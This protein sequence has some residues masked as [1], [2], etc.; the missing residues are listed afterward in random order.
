MNDLYT[1]AGIIEKDVLL[2]RYL[3]LVRYEALKL[4]VRLPASVQLDDLIQ[5]G[6]IGLLDASERFDMTQV[7]AFVT[8]AVQ[9][10]RGAMLDEL[11]ARDWVPRSLC[12]VWRGKR[13][14]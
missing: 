12:A 3:P 11:R 2:E 9:R 10:G 4:Q 7:T 8:Y 14:K 1:Q 13:P 5:A 6:G